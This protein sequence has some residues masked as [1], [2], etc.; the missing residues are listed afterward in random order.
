MMTHAD[1]FSGIGGFIAAAK[2][3]GFKTL[4]SCEIDPQVAEVLFR[5]I[6]EIEKNVD[7]N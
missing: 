6:L 2:S 7:K 1:L 3:A 4:F 5:Y